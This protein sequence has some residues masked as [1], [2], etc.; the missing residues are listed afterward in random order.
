MNILIKNK[1]H[2]L[3]FKTSQAHRRQTLTLEASD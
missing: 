1:T 2:T 3:Q